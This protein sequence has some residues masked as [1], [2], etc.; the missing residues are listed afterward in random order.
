MRNRISAYPFFY[1]FLLVES[2]V[3]NQA[4]FVLL[5][6]YLVSGVELQSRGG[7]SSKGVTDFNCAHLTIIVV[8][9]NQIQTDRWSENCFLSF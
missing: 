2:N 7:E 6:T 9:I 5:D 1:F 3:F 4:I 8:S